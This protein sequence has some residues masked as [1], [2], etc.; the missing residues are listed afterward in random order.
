M[1]SIYSIYMHAFR[2]IYGRWVN[3]KS[4]PPLFGWSK[5]LDGLDSSLSIQTI[6]YT[7]KAHCRSIPTSP[8]RL[9]IF[10]RLIELYHQLS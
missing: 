2:V 1:L 10:W 7:N 5:R 3:C 9:T 4:S 6:Y 8:R